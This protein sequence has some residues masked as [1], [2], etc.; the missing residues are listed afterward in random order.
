MPSAHE[1]I[2]PIA[3]SRAV[4]VCSAKGSRCI[5]RM[6][7]AALA[8]RAGSLDRKARADRMLQYSVIRKNNAISDSDRSVT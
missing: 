4:D 7:R 6:E 8:E 3:Q 2:A 5:F 1:T